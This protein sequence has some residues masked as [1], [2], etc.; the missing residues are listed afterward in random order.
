MKKK[1]KLKQGKKMYLK[2]TMTLRRQREPRGR[3]PSHRRGL[4]QR[5]LQLGPLRGRPQ[6]PRRLQK[7]LERLRPHRRLP[8]NESLKKALQSQRQPELQNVNVK[9]ESK[10]IYLYQR[11]KKY[12][13]FEEVNKTIYQLLS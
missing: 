1:P 9:E 10:F 6:R 8:E 3:R 11:P 2:K 7:R 4:P 12:F 13:M 5:R